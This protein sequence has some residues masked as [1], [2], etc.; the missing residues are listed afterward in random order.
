MNCFEV[1]KEFRD[2]WRKT[3]AS[4]RRHHVIDH[5]NGCAACEAAYRAFALTAPVLHFESPPYAN[6]PRDSAGVAAQFGSSR[7]AAPRLRSNWGAVSACISLVAAAGVAAWLAS[8]APSESISDILG[9]HHPAGELFGGT[10][11]PAALD[12]VGR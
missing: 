5:L 4:G 1:R 9:K 8:A 2:L 3:L 7:S 12:N 6:S 10:D 11:M